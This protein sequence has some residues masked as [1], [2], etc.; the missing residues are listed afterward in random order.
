MSADPA[1]TGVH[2]PLGVKGWK[3]AGLNLNSA[4]ASSTSGMMLMRMIDFCTRALCLTPRMLTTQRT[5]ST[6]CARANCS[7]RLSANVGEKVTA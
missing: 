7:S 1:A 5:Q 2:V 3:F 4:S 6:P